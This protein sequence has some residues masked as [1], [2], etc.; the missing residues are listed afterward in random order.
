VADNN[1]LTPGKII[2]TLIYILLFP[3]LLLSLSGDWLWREGWIFSIWFTVL[4]FATI[5][6]LYRHD[7]ICSLKG[8]ENLVPATRK[9]GTGTWSWDF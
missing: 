7:R 8:I 2:F 5:I 9:D 1:S 4:C 6:R 3:T